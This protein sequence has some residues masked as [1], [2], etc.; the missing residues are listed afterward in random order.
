MTT[1]GTTTSYAINPGSFGGVKTSDAENVFSDLFDDRLS[2]ESATGAED[3]QDSADGQASVQTFKFMGQVVTAT[4]LASQLKA[5]DIAELPEAD[6]QSAMASQLK[7]IEM[8]EHALESQYTD[9]SAPDLSNEPRL[10]SYAT[11]TVGGKVVATI[12]NQG[13]VESS[14]A[15]YLKFKAALSES[16]NNTNGP[17]LAQ[18]RA[19]EIAAAVGG[20]VQKSSTAITQNQFN[21][22]PEV[23]TVSATVDYK[24]MQSDPAYQIIQDMYAQYESTMQRRAQYLS[25][26]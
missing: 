6:Y 10:Q 16:V 12:D 7:S 20:T 2:G 13:S 26:Q 22:L 25:T 21:A 9:Y 17:D 23:A 19:E 15:D 14:D 11:V 5:I 8:S 1:V 3:A 4:N 24:A 18:H